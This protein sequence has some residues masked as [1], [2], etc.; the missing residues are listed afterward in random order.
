MAYY[1]LE[2]KET[3]NALNFAFPDFKFR[4]RQT[5]I[6]EQRRSHPKIK[7]WIISGP[8][9]FGDLPSIAE[10][11]PYCEDLSGDYA[12]HHPFLHAVVK[13][14]KFGT[15]NQ[16]FGYWEYDKWDRQDHWRAAFD[17][18][19]QLGGYGGK[20]YRFR[21]VRKLKGT[22]NYMQA[23]DEA[24]VWTRLGAVA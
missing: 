22:T 13:V 6:S 12:P 16:W 17:M 4:V 10:V 20:P 11:S 15:N 19:I 7:V 23:A 3:L 2:V 21:N 24:I 5:P 14:I 9:D 8:L 1:K 18:D